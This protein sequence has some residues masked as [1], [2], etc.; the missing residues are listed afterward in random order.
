MGKIEILSLVITIVALISFCAVFTVL[1]MNYYKSLTEKV[2]EGK[3]DIDLIDNAI[4]ESK[5]KSQKKTRVT[6]LVLKVVC[7][8]VLAVLI[9]G[10]GMGIYGRITGNVMPIGDTTA[11]VVAS[12]SMSEKNEVNTYLF[13]NNL[14]NQFNTYDIIQVK[15]YGSQNDVK[16]Y[17]VVAFKN[18]DG[19][20]IIHRIV[21]LNVVDG[22]TCYLTR[23]DSNNASDNGSQYTTFLHYSD[24]VGYY[25]GNRVQM[26]GVAVIFL[27]SNSG[28]ITILAVLYALLM[29]DYLRGKYE[30]AAN[31]RT[32]L[33]IELLDYDLN[34]EEANDL[35]TSY[36]ESLTYKGIEYR[37]LGGKFIEK[38]EATLTDAQIDELV[39]VKNENGT[40]TRK[41]KIITSKTSDKE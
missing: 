32:N 34:K 4:Y 15:K 20:V 23:G 5:K 38:S 19:V 10:I 22:E 28:I 41:T 12:G 29:Q 40:T 13:E 25:T 24:I 30:K 2:L 35:D 6:R 36:S 9:A 33:L 31:E 8:A 17:D 27:Q 26:L 21:S 16:Q 37:F 39:V 14:N 18:A 3:E 1:F 11:I 7:Y